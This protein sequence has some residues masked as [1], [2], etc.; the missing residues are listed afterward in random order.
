MDLRGLLAA[1]TTAAL[2][3]FWIVFPIFRGLVTHL[4]ERQ[5]LDLSDQVGISYDRLNR[6]F[7]NCCFLTG[8]LSWFELIAYYSPQT[9]LVPRLSAQGITNL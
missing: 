7:S 8:L 3:L 5:M 1:Q 6:N 2:T 9:T 4:G